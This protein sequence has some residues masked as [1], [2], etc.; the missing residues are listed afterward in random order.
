MPQIR[1]AIIEDDSIWST[2]LSEYLEQQEGM[3]V[4]VIAKSYEE[5]LAIDIKQIDVALIDLSLDNEQEELQGL[6]LTK[7]FRERSFNHAIVLTSWDDEETI[8]QA[9]QAGAINYI[10]KNSYED[11]PIMIQSVYAGKPLIHGDAA[12]TLLKSYRQEK[13][14]RDLTPPEKEVYTLHKKGCTK[15]DIAQ[16]L[17]KSPDTIKMQLREAKKKVKKAKSF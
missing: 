6:K 9:F 12:Q 14:M 1:V 17:I 15:R 4:S 11:L 2:L 10:T 16:K 13:D 5:A 7:A 8:D 3:H